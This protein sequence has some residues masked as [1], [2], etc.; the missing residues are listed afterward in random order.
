MKFPPQFFITGTDTDVGKTFVSAILTAGLR[1]TYWKPVQSGAKD[2]T[3]TQTVQRLS[4][5]DDSHFLPETY[6]LQEPL[7]PHAA[8]ELEGVR[9]DAS[10]LKLPATDSYKT[11]HLLIEGAGGLFVPINWEYQL[12][13]LLED[14][15]I[16]VILLVRSGL[17][18]LNHTQLSIEALQRRGIPIFGL[19]MNGPLNQTNRESLSKLTRVPILAEIP[20]IDVNAYTDFAKLFKQFFHA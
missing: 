3:D 9:I 13:D 5:L 14:W 7:S 1:A 19:V 8:A 18:T 15:K 2:G 4:K 12:I 6:L 16:P 11:E 10:N 17:G 20:P